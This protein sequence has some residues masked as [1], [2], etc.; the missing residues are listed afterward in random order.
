[1]NGMIRLNWPTIAGGI[2]LVGVLTL[3]PRTSRTAEIHLLSQVAAAPLAIFDGRS[4]GARPGGALFDTKPSRDR[5]SPSQ[6]AVADTPHERVL[7]LVQTPGAV[8]TDVPATPVAESFPSDVPTP[9]A[10]TAPTPKRTF[11]EELPGVANQLP[12]DSGP[13]AYEAQYAALADRLGSNCTDVRNAKLTAG[14]AP[15]AAIIGLARLK[16]LSSACSGT[17]AIAGGSNAVS[18]VPGFS[19]GGGSDYKQ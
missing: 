17:G 9:A 11:A 8:V 6:P 4:P 12:A 2:A 13:D 7:S 18:M 1:M 15:R 14:E 3:V 19:V 16:R 5:S 10:V